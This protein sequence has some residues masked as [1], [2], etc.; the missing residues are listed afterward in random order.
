M[1]G[2][3]V[4]HKPDANAA[5]MAFMA[6]WMPRSE[7]ATVA[8]MVRRG[9]EREYFRT[10]MW[11]QKQAIEAMPKMRATESVEDPTVGLHYFKGGCDWHIT[12]A[13]EE[14]GEIMAFGLANLGY[15]GDLGYI[16]ITE[17]VQHGVE[18]DLHFRPVPLST[19]REKEGAVS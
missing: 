5:T 10:L 1:S 7:H 11:K 17:L 12:E 2:A 4:S 15:G 3:I 13:W 14:D 18:L 16:S 9:E 6:R 8:A 19:V